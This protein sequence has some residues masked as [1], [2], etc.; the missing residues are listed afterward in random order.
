MASSDIWYKENTNDKIWWLDNSDEIEGV[1]IFSFDK[2]T[3]YNLFADRDK[4]TPAQKKI[5]YDENPFWRE[6]FEGK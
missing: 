6:Y 1:F 3:K 4:L 2:K 5:F